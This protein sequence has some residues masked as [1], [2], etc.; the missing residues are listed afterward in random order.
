MTKNL[1]PSLIIP[2]NATQFFIDGPSGKLDCLQLNPGDDCLINITPRSNSIQENTDNKL[3][4]KVALI[5]HPDPKGGGTYTNKVVQTI[6]NSLNAKGFTCYCPNL[7]GVGKSDGVHDFGKG[8][9]EDALAVYNYVNSIHKIEQVVLAGFSF[10]CAIASGLSTHIIDF[11]KL[12]LAGPAV[13]KYNI[14]VISN[15]NTIA[16]HGEDDEVVA[17]EAV[18]IWSRENKLPLILLP[19]TSHFFHG[20]LPMLKNIINNLDL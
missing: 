2:K 12:I 11:D 14:P 9:I 17:L 6:A 19:E 7:R 5:F 16:I 3:N 1:Y 13:T 15:L 18:R 20:R 8:E 4:P 10:G